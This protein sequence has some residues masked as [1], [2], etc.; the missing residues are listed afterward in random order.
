ME[1]ALSAHS[2]SFP[3]VAFIEMYITHRPLLSLNY[4]LTESDCLTDC[5]IAAGPRQRSDS[6]FRVP[7]DS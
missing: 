6:W 7:R 3:H 4:C 1:T 5:Q 2:L